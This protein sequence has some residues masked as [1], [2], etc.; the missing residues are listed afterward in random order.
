[1]TEEDTFSVQE[2]SA[3]NRDLLAVYMSTEISVESLITVYEALGASP[4][5]RIAVK[6]STG[7]PG[8]NYLCT[9]LI[10]DFVIIFKYPIDLFCNRDM[11]AFRDI[12]TYKIRGEN[13]GKK[14]SF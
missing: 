12:N 6:L 13:Y 4:S 1:M 7:E 11:I 14:N 8:S 2:S 5:G 10:G 3:G 9:D